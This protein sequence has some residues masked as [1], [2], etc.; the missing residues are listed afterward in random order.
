M[1]T[2]IVIILIVLINLTFQSCSIQKRVYKPGYNIDFYGFQK[3]TKNTKSVIDSSLVSE[4]ELQT[5]ST[6]NDLS[7]ISL[8][9]QNPFLETCDNI[10]LKNGNEIKCKVEDIGLDVVKYKKCENITGPSYSILKKDIFM[11]KY[12]NGTKDIFNEIVDSPPAQQQQ[13]QQQPTYNDN[14]HKTQENIT[15]N[16]NSDQY[17]NNATKQNTT[18]QK[19]KTPVPGIIGDW[20]GA[21]AFCLFFFVCIAALLGDIIIILCILLILL[22]IVAMILEI[23]S[24]SI[25]R[26]NPEKYGKPG[27]GGIIIY[28]I[29]I[30]VPFILLLLAI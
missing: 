30:G 5:A 7:N 6:E 25:K 19:K 24:N 21:L 4:P 15:Q 12:A 28:I 2:K 18:T 17:A 27:K 22:S 9:K 3:T 16:N 29:M 23:I 26:K 14:Q 8:K 11:I 1:K 10:I 20:I 13:Q